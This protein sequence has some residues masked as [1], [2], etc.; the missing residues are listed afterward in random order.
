MAV[1][2]PGR[3]L[4]AFRLVGW[5]DLEVPVFVSVYSCGGVARSVPCRLIGV[6][7]AVC[8]AE[9]AGSFLGVST[10]CLAVLGF[11]RKTSALLT[12]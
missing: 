5:I 10:H 9:V 12:K 7:G 3:P 4:S 8:L 6:L 2:A 1:A 11:T